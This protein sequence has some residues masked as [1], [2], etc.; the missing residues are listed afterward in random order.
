[1]QVFIS[2]SGSGAKAV[3]TAL[4]GWLPLLV[5]D[6]TLLNSPPPPGTRSSAIRR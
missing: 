2:W 1:M 5:P 6:A 4:K 3:A